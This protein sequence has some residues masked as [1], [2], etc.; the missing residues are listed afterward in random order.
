MFIA[1]TQN[2]NEKYVPSLGNLLIYEET[3]KLITPTDIRRFMLDNT[4]S[5]Y[6]IECN[7]FPAIYRY[8]GQSY[9]FNNDFPLSWFMLTF[10]HTSLLNIT[11]S[12]IVE[13]CNTKWDST[14]SYRVSEKYRTS[15]GIKTFLFV[16]NTQ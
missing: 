10:T 6:I 3:E 16:Y 9:N 14:K 5:I 11:V 4:A 8:S 1:D 15:N 2:L 13:F 12:N 7:G